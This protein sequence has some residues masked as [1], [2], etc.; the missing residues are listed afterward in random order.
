MGIFKS[1]SMIA[2]S[3]FIN[4]MCFMSGRLLRIE[5]CGERNIT[6]I[7]TGIALVGYNEQEKHSNCSSK[8]S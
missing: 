4:T 1:S 6:V 2:L 8:R 5:I 3:E 7:V